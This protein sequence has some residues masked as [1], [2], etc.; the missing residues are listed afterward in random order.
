MSRAAGVEFGLVRET[1]DGRMVYRLY[2]GGGDNVALRGGPGRRII[3]HTHP[4]GGR[5]P[6]EGPFSDMENINKAF[7]R[8]LQIDPTSPVPHR[9]VIWGDGDFDSTLYF[10]DIL[11]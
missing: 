11:R 10:P 8:S 1:I 3:G 7:L 4:Q 5:Y 2:S 9:R 6:S